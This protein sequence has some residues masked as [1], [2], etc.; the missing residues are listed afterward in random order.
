MKKS[1]NCSRR[2]D[3]SSARLIRP[4]MKW[5]VQRRRYRSSSLHVSKAGWTHCASD[6]SVFIVAQG[7][8]ERLGVP[9]SNSFCRGWIQLSKMTGFAVLRDSELAGLPKSYFPDVH[10]FNLMSMCSL[11]DSCARSGALKP[12]CSMASSRFRKGD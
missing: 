8:P 12:T 3:T 5:S 2:K 9:M 6:Q 4:R 7:K 1:K 10:V 11:C